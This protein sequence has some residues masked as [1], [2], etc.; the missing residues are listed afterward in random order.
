[1]IHLSYIYHMDENHDHKEGMHLRASSLMFLRAKAL[2]LRMTRSETILWDVLRNQQFMGLKFR[3]QHP[4]LKYILDFYCHQLQ[5]GVEVDGDTHNTKEAR[6]Y[7]KAR[8]EALETYG[9]TIIRFSNEQ[10]LNNLEGVKREL[11]EVVTQLR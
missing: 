9:F 2:R 8:T 4:V 5:L 3:K 10:V 1:M 6:L 7:D 11:R